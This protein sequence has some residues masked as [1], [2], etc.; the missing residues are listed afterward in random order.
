MYPCN[1]A[2]RLTLNQVT[3]KTEMAALIKSFA[4]AAP[5]K[6]AKAAKPA[7]A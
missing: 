1:L 5:A 6:A 4:P 7:K 3:G 2:K